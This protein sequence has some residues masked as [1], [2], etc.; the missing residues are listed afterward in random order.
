VIGQVRGN[1][2]IVRLQEVLQHKQANSWCWVNFLG[3]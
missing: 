3:L 2:T 1:A